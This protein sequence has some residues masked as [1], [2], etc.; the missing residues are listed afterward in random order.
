MSA[1]VRPRPGKDPRIVTFRGALEALID[2]L[3][4]TVSITRWPN[5]GEPIPLPLLQSAARLQDRL[6]SATRLANGKFVGAPT[7]V[8]TSDAIREAVQ[9]LDGAFLVYCRRVDGTA[10]ERL[11]AATALDAVL[12][13]IK[14]AA[15]RWE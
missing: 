6:G 10:D 7:F 9:A 2:S 5:V 1:P 4:A 8:N 11:E 13:R 15:S 3:D 14:L 12:G